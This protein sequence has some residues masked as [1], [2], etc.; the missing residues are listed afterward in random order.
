MIYSWKASGFHCNMK[1]SLTESFQNT[2]QKSPKI[3]PSSPTAFKR[4]RTGRNGR[5]RRRCVFVGK[6]EKEDIYLQHVYPLSCFSPSDRLCQSILLCGALSLIPYF[7]SGDAC[8][9]LGDGERQKCVGR[10]KAICCEKQDQAQD[11]ICDILKHF[12][13]LRRRS[14]PADV[15]CGAAAG[16]DSD[17]EFMAMRRIHF[18]V[19]MN[20]EMSAYYEALTFVQLKSHLSN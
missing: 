1:H 18:A 12:G 8:A 14:E 20:E 7:M 4:G 15:A 16:D 19:M 5:R 6:D 3:T 10:R 9:R 13:A 11:F 17:P 2:S